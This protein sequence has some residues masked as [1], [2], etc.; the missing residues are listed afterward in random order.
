MVFALTYENMEKYINNQESGNG[1][2]LL[3]TKNE[4]IN[5]KNKQNKSNSQTKIKI[6]CSCGNEF[7]IG[8]NAF[9]S[10]NQK[11]CLECGIEKRVGLR[12]KNTEYF[13]NEVFKLVGEEYSVLNEYINDST[14]IKIRHNCLKC[15]NYEYEVR[16]NGFIQG[17]RCPKCAG[18]IKKTNKEFLKQVYE[19]T[20]D[21][22]T[23][24]EDY[25]GANKKILVRHNCSDCNNYEWRITPLNFLK[26]QKC[27]KCQHKLS[28]KP[29]KTLE[30]FKK[31]VYSIVKDEYTV[32]GKAYINTNTKIKIRHNNCYF[33]YEVSPNNFLRGRRCPFCKKSKGEIK[34]K[35]Y[36]DNKHMD[37]KME[38]SFD[39]LQGDFDLLRFDFAILDKENN[40]KLLI[41]YDGEFHYRPIMG[42]ENLNKQQTYDNLKNDYCK[43][44]NIK[45]LRIPYW[46]FDNLE[47]ILDEELK[48]K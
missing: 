5:E 24:L 15:N 10:G 23:I 47:K 26:G 37:Y 29:T 36:L 17:A 43:I 45:L 7:I 35:E 21:E 48:N 16:P 28:G 27:P 41:E 20:N 46:N 12:R 18:N 33:I 1:C 31:E 25:K 19:I 42:E 2:V 8:F 6:K 32:L 40:L 4:F 9:K 44:N 30:G 13:K 14:K 3:T 38:Y 11:Q 34:I 39:D 22:Y